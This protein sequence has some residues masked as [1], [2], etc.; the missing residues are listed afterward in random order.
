MGGVFKMFVGLLAVELFGNGMVGSSGKTKEKLGN[1]FRR[2]DKRSRGV[3]LGE[4]TRRVHENLLV[5]CELF[6]AQR[7]IKHLDVN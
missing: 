5:F 4:V 7:I 2:E 6:L 3:F 1:G